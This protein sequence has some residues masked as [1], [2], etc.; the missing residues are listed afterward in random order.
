MPTGAAGQISYPLQWTESGQGLEPSVRK[1]LFDFA[2]NIAAT[3]EYF[4][5]DWRPQTT[6]TLL[7]ALPVTQCSE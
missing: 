6:A 2:I 5:A 4:D 1:L 7:T 3:V